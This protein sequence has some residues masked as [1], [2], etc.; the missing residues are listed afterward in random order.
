MF[1]YK[2]EEA[3]RK[4]EQ[5]IK[6]E[7]QLPEK[8][9]K[10]INLE[11]AQKLVNFCAE[12]Q[13]PIEIID[14][15]ENFELGEVE[16]ENLKKILFRVSKSYLNGPIFT[17]KFGKDHSFEIGRR[18]WE[19]DNEQLMKD[20]NNENVAKYYKSNRLGFGNCSK[21]IGFLNYLVDELEDLQLTKELSNIK[22]KIPLELVE[23][24]ENGDL[25]YHF[26][27]DDK[28]VE[29]VKKFSEIVKELVNTLEKEDALR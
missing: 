28:K 18:K 23:N 22:K 6:E 14:Y 5:E 3:Q 7:I 29:L 9:V 17:D 27:E 21:V 15:G 24:N 4:K 10:K 20:K 8:K 2:F 16:K 1:K 13:N 25:K 11:K 26:L 19:I 12:H